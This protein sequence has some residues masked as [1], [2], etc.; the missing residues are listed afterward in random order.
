MGSS[1]M[2]SVSA[3]SVEYQR[4][5]SHRTDQ[6]E[7]MYKYLRQK[8]V[9]AAVAIPVINQ[10]KRRL[11]T[12]ALVVEGSVTALSLLSTSLREALKYEIYHSTMFRYP[13]FRWWNMLSREG[14][15]NLCY[16]AVESVSLL[17]GDAL[18]VE[19][20]DSLSAYHIM[21][22]TLQ[23]LQLPASS[24]VLERTV[25][26]IEEQL[27]CEAALWSK[28]RHVGKGEACTLCEAAGIH[29]AEFLRIFAG[30]R[31]IY[32][33]FAAY[34][35][36][37]HRQL[38]NAH[39]PQVAW[40][41][42][43]NIP[44]TDFEAIIQAMD[45]KSRELLQMA[46]VEG[47][48]THGRHA[49]AEIRQEVRRGECILSF[50]DSGNIERFVGL[51]VLR[52]EDQDGLILT[53]LGKWKNE[54]V[55]TC[56]QLPCAKQGILDPSESIEY[57]LE[58]HLA[59]LRNCIQVRSLDPE[60]ESRYGTSGMGMTTK[61]AKQIY[62][63][64]LDRNLP[65]PELAEVEVAGADDMMM[66]GTGSS[67]MKL[68]WPARGKNRYLPER[69]V[70]LL[71]DGKTVHVYGWLSPLEFDQFN[72]TTD[73][74]D[75]WLTTLA[76]PSETVELANDLFRNATMSSTPIHF[77]SSEASL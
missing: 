3:K 26:Q 28:W 45:A 7:M 21:S 17:D 62:H 40:P 4:L 74:Q 32:C 51:S 71:A 22:G 6:L 56:C 13:L 54:R 73:P 31:V 46:M 70:F 24:M 18:F 12:E 58:R 60:V 14:I 11:N 41:T 23:Y 48:S 34:G 1:L 69:K 33:V 16:N 67:S 10:I 25:F 77:S 47:T 76:V 39:P 19:S 8:S 44:L 5:R 52:V 61:Y 30:Y 27:I 64:T 53:K 35:V 66:D 65:M 29:V 37:F 72:D 63:A 42:D 2:S 59:P 43:I 36:A 50:G 49:R 75:M 68:A 15:K 57:I 55:R 9:K 20:S 38:V